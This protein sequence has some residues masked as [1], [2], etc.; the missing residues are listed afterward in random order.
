MTDLRWRWPFLLMTGLKPREIRILVHR[1]GLLTGQDKTL[2]E[3][4]RVFGISGERIRQIEARILR[5]FRNPRRWRARGLD[6]HEIGRLLAAP[7][8]WYAALEKAD[9]PPLLR[10][11]RLCKCDESVTTF[12][13]LKY[14]IPAGCCDVCRQHYMREKQHKI[15]SKSHPMSRDFHVSRVGASRDYYPYQKAER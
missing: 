8:P 13:Q 3:T 10:V 15:R 7:D 1:Y 14:R 5:M 4:A 11:C 2:K 12:G 9:P 6:K